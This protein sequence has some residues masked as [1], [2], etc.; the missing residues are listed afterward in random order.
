MN[1]A[2]HARLA[3]GLGQDARAPPPRFILAMR[4]S[5][6]VEA[7]PTHGRDARA[8]QPRYFGAAARTAVTNRSVTSESSCSPSTSTTVP[9]LL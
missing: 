9:D 6:T 1:P 7:T 3:R 5:E 4:G 8:T 2:R